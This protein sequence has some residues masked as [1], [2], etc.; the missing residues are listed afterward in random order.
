[1]DR[2]LIGIGIIT[3]TGFDDLK[4]LIDVFEGRRVDTPWG[5]VYVQE[6]EQGGVHLFH[7]NRHAAHAP[8]RDRKWRLPHYV[9]R[10][11]NNRFLDPRPNIVALAKLGVRRILSATAVGTPQDLPVGSIVLPTDH[12]TPEFGILTLA[13]ENS[14]AQF[15]QPKGKVFC[16]NPHGALV[17]AL[18]QRGLVSCAS[19]LLQITRGPGF[20]SDADYEILRREGVTIVGMH[21]AIPEAYCCHELGLCYTAA[22]IITDSL[23]HHPDQAEIE[24]IGREVGRP[25]FGVLCDLAVTSAFPSPCTCTK[26]PVPGLLETL[27][28]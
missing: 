2:P 8:L 12:R 3:G 4:G 17:E 20:E 1:M 18:H 5:T 7:L 21:T 16:G 14:R 25:L 11:G 13:G 10:D 9:D 19:G 26:H 6:F 27:A 23:S 28:A 15:H 22:A 24:R